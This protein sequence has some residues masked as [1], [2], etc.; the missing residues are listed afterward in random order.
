MPH[1]G[2]LS[3]GALFFSFGSPAAAPAAQAAT[4]HAPLFEAAAQ[5]VD[6]PPELTQAI[7]QGDLTVTAGN[8][9]HDEFGRLLSSVSTMAAQLR[10]LVSDVR[11]SVHS[12]STAS[13]EKCS[14]MPRLSASSTAGGRSKRVSKFSSTP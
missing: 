10:S 8:D 13:A 6:V 11:T 12:I 5:E 9:R 7:A 4:E 1:G 2:F 14:A 3:A